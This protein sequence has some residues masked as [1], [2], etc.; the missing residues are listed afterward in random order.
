MVWTVGSGVGTGVGCGGG[1]AGLGREGAG[2]GGLGAGCAGLGVD[3]DGGGEAARGGLRRGS[4]FAGSAGGAGSGEAATGA[5][6]AWAATGC[7]SADLG[8]LCAGGG[9]LPTW[10]T[11]PGALRRA[12]RAVPG[13]CRGSPGTAAW[14]TRNAPADA[15]ANGTAVASAAPTLTQAA[16]LNNALKTRKRVTPCSPEDTPPPNWNIDGRCPQDI[17]RR[18]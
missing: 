1:G 7:V 13:G 12:S 17:P 16:R 18:G 4:A 14:S 5:R 15:L 11:S 2:C 8:R 6:P 10:T 9:V 3:G